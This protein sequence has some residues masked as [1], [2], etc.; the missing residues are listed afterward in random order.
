VHD[1]ENLKVP[2]VGICSK[3]TQVGSFTQKNL[4][5]GRVM[6]LWVPSSLRPTHAV[7]AT[8][9]KLS[10]PGVQYVLVGLQSFIEHRWYSVGALVGTSVGSAVGASVGADEIEIA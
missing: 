5:A 7:F 8:E 6:P 9:R 3:D 4:A 1:V 2:A 10:S